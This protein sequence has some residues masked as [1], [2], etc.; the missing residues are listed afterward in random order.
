MLF[1]GIGRTSFFL[2]AHFF[3]NR[4]QSIIYS[5]F[6]MGFCLFLLIFLT[7]RIIISILFFILG[8]AVGSSYYVSL[9]LLMK[10]ELNRKGAKAGIFESLIGFGSAIT[11]IIAGGLALFSLIMP[12]FT[13]SL[14]AIIFGCF[15]FLYQKKKITD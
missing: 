9:E 15:L 14:F 12:F 2:V 11:P 1:F 3:K 6:L 13:F 8:L 4:F 10:Y 5:L 7:N